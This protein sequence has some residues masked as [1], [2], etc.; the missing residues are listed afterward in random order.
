MPRVDQSVVLTAQP[1][2]RRHPQQEQ[3][4]RFQDASGLLQRADVAGDA[5]VIDDLET[6]DRI[7]G[8]VAERKSFDRRPRQMVEAAAARR[9]E[10]FPGKVDADNLS[11]AAKLDRCP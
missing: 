6:S 8:R 2:V 5:E 1:I 7:E 3:S 4:T 10:R 9:F 11:E